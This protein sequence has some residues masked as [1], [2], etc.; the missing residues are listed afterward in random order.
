MAS[1]AEVAF[2]QDLWFME[3]FILFRDIEKRSL[4]DLC[5]TAL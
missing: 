5:F 3:L 2:L 4:A 1:P